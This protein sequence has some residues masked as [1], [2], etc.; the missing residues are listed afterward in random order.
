M[1]RST[2]SESQQD[3]IKKFAGNLSPGDIAGIL[4]KR[5][6]ASFKKE[7]VNYYINCNGL[8]KR[9][10]YV[11]LAILD[12]IRSVISEPAT[13]ITKLVNKK[14][15]TT[16]KETGIY[17]LIKKIGGKVKGTGRGSKGK[18]TTRTEER[19]KFIKSIKKGKTIEE[20]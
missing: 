19:I 15:G 7:Q 6:K 8:P 5:F 20:I 10:Y 12:F 17:S 11:D 14:F 18:L 13:E 3:I 4:N 9:K 1:P 16:Y 2:F